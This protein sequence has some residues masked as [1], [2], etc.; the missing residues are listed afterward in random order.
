MAGFVNVDHSPLCEPDQLLDL[1]DLPWPWEDSLVEEIVMHH[2]LEHL[3]QAPKVFLG[4]IKELY[5]VMKPGGVLQIIVPHSRSDGYLID[6]THVRPITPQ[7]FDLLSKRLNREWVES[8]VAS[9]PLALQLD[10]D[11]ELVETLY[12]LRSAW[13]GVPRSELAHATDTYFNVV[14]QVTLTVRRV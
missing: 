12:E 8:G 1:E 6:P 10:V 5:R 7:L 11:F 9:T 14:D 4:V 2:V 3:G 13:K